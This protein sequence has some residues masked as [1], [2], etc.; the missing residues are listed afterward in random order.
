[1]HQE[2]ES[3]VHKEF[4]SPSNLLGFGKRWKCLASLEFIS[5]SLVPLWF[6][7]GPYDHRY[8]RLWSSKSTWTWQWTQTETWER[9]VN[10]RFKGEMGQAD[11]GFFN[12]GVGEWAMRDYKNTEM[13]EYLFLRWN[14]RVLKLWH[15]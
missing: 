8:K 9:V 1:M 11:F 2:P 14:R 7:R 3:F 12:T 15:F 4:Q 5:L 10:I 13:L 6:G